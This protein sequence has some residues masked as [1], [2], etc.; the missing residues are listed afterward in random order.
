MAPRTTDV[1]GLDAAVAAV[2][3][4]RDEWARVPVPHRIALLRRCLDGYLRTAD[5][6]VAEGCRA[7]GIDPAS[8]MAGEEWLSGPIAV[9]RQIRLLVDSLTGIQRTGY[10]QLPSGAVHRVPTG[11]LAVRVFPRGSMDRV[12]YPGTRMDVW[13]QPDVDETTLRGTMAPMYRGARPAGT[14]ALVLGA[15]NVAAIAP[16]DVL[17]KLFVEHSVVVLKMHPVNAYLG[18]L[19][20]RAFE[21]LVTPGYLRIVYGDVVEGQHLIH[22]AGVDTVHMTGSTAVHDRIVWGD[23]PDEQARRRAAGTPTLAK[24]V[25]S[26]LGCVTP[27]VVVPGRWS[28]G[29]L[30][31]QAEH[32]A[33]MVAH[34]ASCTC[35]AAKVLVTWRA[36]PQRQAFLDRV[37]AVLSRHAPRTAYYP[38]AADRYAAFVR[39]HPQARRLREAPGG[40]LGCATIYDVD[41]S[42]AGD[43]VFTEEAWSPVIAETSLDARSEAA[44]IG[45]AVEFCNGRVFGTLSMGMLVSPRSLRERRGAIH[46]AVAALRYGTVSINHWSGINFVL[47]NGPWGAYPG[48]TLHDVVSGIGVVHNPLMFARPLKTV[49]WG[50]FTVWPKPAWFVTHRRAD[51]V[52]RRIAAFEA[53]PSVWRLPAIAWAAM[54]S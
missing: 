8:V 36:W 37:A 33:T 42:L 18:P 23:T 40:T 46:E 45:E 22:H 26:E 32:V 5:D 41:P 7:K 30:Q 29:E 52:T 14:V 11:E 47:G 17:Y 44:F 38:G 4:R 48:H 50:P 54:R 12:M 15:G 21:A 20:E 25:T 16:T 1:P 35:I 31:Y 43:L 27:T 19:L 6:V 3:G 24:P 2:R 9:I 28:D 10:P 34:G 13:M 53:A 49:A 51:A 39:A